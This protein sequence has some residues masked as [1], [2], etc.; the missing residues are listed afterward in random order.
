MDNAEVYA[1]KVIS[2]GK[3]SFRPTSAFVQPDNGTFD[4]NETIFGLY[5]NDERA[6]MKKLNING[7]A[8]SSLVLSSGYAS[9]YEK[10]AER[11]PTTD[12]RPGLMF[13]PHSAADL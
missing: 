7:S 3:F 9:I 10:D 13:R 5:V 2:S 12:F 4:L 1:E 11:R 8:S 6:M